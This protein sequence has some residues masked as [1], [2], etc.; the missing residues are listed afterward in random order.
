MLQARLA[1]R[2]EAQYGDFVEV[3]T[4]P[5]W[6]E[7][8]HGCRRLLRRSKDIA[9]L[10]WLCRARTRL[11]QAEGLLQGLAILAQSLHAW[12]EALHPQLCIEGEHDPAVRAGALGALVDPDGLIADIRAIAIGTCAGVHLTVRDVERAHAEPHPTD[13][14]SPAAM[15]RQLAALRTERQALDDPLSQLAQCAALVHW[16]DA[17]STC[18][19]GDAAP[20][21]TPL[22][23]LLDRCCPP[24]AHR[25][26]QATGTAPVASVASSDSG[27]P[28]TRE[29]ALH[30]MRQA[31]HWFEQHEP[32]S[33][34]PLLLQRAERMVGLGFLRVADVVPLEL[35]R[36]WEGE[37]GPLAG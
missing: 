34:V 24:A 5:D 31:R 30:A 10:V 9:L 18:H 8:E 13:A 25:S 17:W 22:S 35:L 3:A 20:A 7:I 2:V 23:R 11:A 29:D 14:P 33:P 32:S 19:L 6:T 26:T 15:Q 16:I 27:T 1:P 21:L 28:T 36:K 37:A 4:S 12:P